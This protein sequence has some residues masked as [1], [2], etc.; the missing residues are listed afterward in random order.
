MKRRFVAVAA[1]IV[2]SLLPLAGCVSKPPLSNEEL[3]VAAMADAV[4][5]EDSEVMELVCLT[6]QDQQVI[7][8]EAGE[9]VLLVTWHNYAE[10]CEP[11]EVLG[12]KDIWA[13]SL[14]ELTDWCLENGSG[15]TDWELR[16]AQ[17]LGVHADE[18][19]THFT[20][21]CFSL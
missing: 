3:W 15:V 5:S 13:T 19:Y 2:L 17:L 8:D 1:G 14:G 9:R 12:H 6:R 11:G 10:P 18:G 16:F 7:W 21:F 4:F 20:A